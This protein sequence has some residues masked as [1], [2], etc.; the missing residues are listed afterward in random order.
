VTYKKKFQIPRT[1]KKKKNLSPKSRRRSYKNKKKFP[2]SE[3]EA[4]D[5]QKE[6]PKSRPKLNNLQKEKAKVRSEETYKKENP[7]SNSK[8]SLQKE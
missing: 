2:K 8:R 5:L 6:I 4:K 7:R 3:V 1:Y